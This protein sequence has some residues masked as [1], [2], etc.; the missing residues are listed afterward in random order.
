MDRMTVL[1][2]LVVMVGGCDSLR[3]APSETIRQNSLLQQR[4]TTALVVQAKE[5]QTSD[6][7]Q[8]LAQ[9]AVRQSEAVLAYTG[10]PKTLP[11][12]ETVDDLLSEQ[13]RAITAQAQADGQQR[14][15]VW[16]VTDSL[17]ELSLALAGLI[18][19]VYGTRAVRTIRQLRRK[20]QA[21]REVVQGN[22]LFKMQQPQMKDT[23]KQA[24]I[25][26]TSETRTL[27]AE[28]KR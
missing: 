23:F 14:P 22:E 15:D 21:L 6:V 20:S 16:Q 8:S 5:E 7:L 18:G 3:L 11:Q 10:F 27:V 12:G 13:S 25:A 28:V 24:H 9:R 4:T 26:Q 1:F 2:G 19:G 17:L